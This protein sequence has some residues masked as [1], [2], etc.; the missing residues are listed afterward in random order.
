MYY[1]FCGTVGGLTGHGP[2]I[3]RFWLKVLYRLIPKS[4][5]CFY[6][7][8]FL[9]GIVWY[10]LVSERIWYWYKYMYLFLSL[11]IGGKNFTVGNYIIL[12]L[13]WTIRQF[14]ALI[15]NSPRPL[16]V[17][18][19]LADFRVKPELCRVYK[20][21]SLVTF[22]T[23]DIRDSVLWS[24]GVTSGGQT[25]VDIDGHYCVKAQLLQGLFQF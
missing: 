12:D 3:Q 23:F 5:G 20:V 16:F 18:K 15:V 7:C 22:N 11:D 14:L 4:R 21:N 6:W 10:V 8:L 9:D 1:H 13:I 24:P 17:L 25:Q 2:K 19:P